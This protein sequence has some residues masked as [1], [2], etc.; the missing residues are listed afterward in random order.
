MTDYPLHS[1]LSMDLVVATPV[2]LDL[3]FVGLDGLPVAGEE[4]FAADLRA[5]RPAAARS[6]PSPRPAWALA[7]AIAAPLGRRPAGLA[8]SAK[9]A[10]AEGVGHRRAHPAARTPTTVVPPRPTATAPW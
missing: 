6:P 8:R 10:E 9:V 7:A 1:P 2:F 4:R 5:D 3:T